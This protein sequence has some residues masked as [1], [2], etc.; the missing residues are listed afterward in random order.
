MVFRS[1][2]H[3]VGYYPDSD[4]HQRGSS[5]PRSVPQHQGFALQPP[6]LQPGFEA[7]GGASRFDDAARI[8]SRMQGGGSP[9][10]LG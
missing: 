7:G 3:G 5:T 9:F 4:L 6:H 10:A 1:G 2:N 8:R